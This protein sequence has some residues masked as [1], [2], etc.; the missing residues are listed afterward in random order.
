MLLTIDVG[1]TKTTVGLFEGSTLVDSWYFDTVPGFTVEDASAQLEL[2]MEQAWEAGT[3]PKGQ[4]PDAGA[5]SCVVAPLNQVWVN[6]MRANYGVETVVCIGSAAD[7]LGL[8]GSSVDNIDEVGPDLVADGIAARA[9]YGC[10]V[11]I[12]DFGTATTIEA[13]DENGYFAGVSIAPGAESSIAAL[14][15]EASAIEMVPVQAPAHV[16]GKNTIESVQS[17][18]VFGEAARAD[19]LIDMCLAE[20]GYTPEQAAQVPVVATGGLCEIISDHSRRITDVDRFLTLKGLMIMEAAA[21]ARAQAEEAEA[22]TAAEEVRVAEAE[23]EAARLAEEEAAAEVARLAAEAE[24]RAAAGRSNTF[25]ANKVAA[26]KG[27]PFAR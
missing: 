15:K 10:P 2:L 16:L 24:A 19:G 26:L 27:S 18:I 4:G 12:V 11:I 17:G 13:M 1:N 7:A 25:A 14:F 23:A 9:I 5:L 6:A 3:A 22:E 20:L 8:Y 21:R